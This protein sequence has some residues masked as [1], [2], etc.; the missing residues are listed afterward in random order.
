[1]TSSIERGGAFLLILLTSLLHLSGI[2]AA[3]FSS[4]GLTLTLLAPE[5]VILTE[6]DSI[7]LPAYT[8]ELAPAEGLLDSQIEVNI[9]CSYCL[10]KMAPY[11]RIRLQQGVI[12]GMGDS[13]LSA[14]GAPD[15]VREALARGG[16]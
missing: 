16:P 12:D 15:L 13:S 9:S 11:S 14:I 1:M 8:V 3:R 10:L 7:D 6:T 4:D 5:A 2:N